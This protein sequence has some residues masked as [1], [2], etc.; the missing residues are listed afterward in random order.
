MGKTLDEYH[1]IGYNSQS[2]N[3]ETI[4]KEISEELEI[5]VDEKD[6][7]AITYLNSEQKH[8]YD[9]ILQKLIT[10]NQEH[11]L[12]MVLVEVEKHSYTEQFLQR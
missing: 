1:L 11:F 7:A 2:K 10:K 4:S 9:I 8:A 12:L 6:I 3:D 5:V